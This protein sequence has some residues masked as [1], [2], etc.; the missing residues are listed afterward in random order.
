MDDDQI[1]NGNSM[2]IDP[3]GEI[4]A[5]CHKLDDDVTVALCTADKVK[6]SS[7]RRYLRARRPE[8]YKELVAP[9]AQAAVTKPGWPLKSDAEG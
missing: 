4:I 6:Q 7:G 1:R 8:L 9:S 5:E 2:I 3:F